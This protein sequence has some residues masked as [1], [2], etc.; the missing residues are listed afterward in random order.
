MESAHHFFKWNDLESEPGIFDST[1]IA[2]N[3]GAV[4]WV[5]PYYDLRV[6][7]TI[8]I[9]NTVEKE[10]PSDL[11]DTPY[12]DPL[13]IERFKIMLDTL[14]AHIPDVDLMV[15]NI[16]NE[17]DILFGTNEDEYAAFG[18]FLDSIV[19]YAK[20]R[21]ADLYDKELTIGAIM[22]LHGLISDDRG[23]L[24]AALNE[25]TDVISTTYYPLDFDF[26][27]QDPEV[28]FEDFDALIE[29]YSDSEQLIYFSECGYASSETCNSSEEQQAHFFSNVFE[30]WDLHMDRIKYLTIFKL[31]DWTEA[32]VIAFGE[33]YDI[34]DPIFLE[35]LRTLG[36]R[37]EFGDFKLAYDFILC[38]LAARD[39]CAVE[40]DLTTTVS[41]EQETIQ[42]YPQ[43]AINQLSVSLNANEIKEFTLF[44][45][46]GRIVR[47]SSSSSMMLNQIPTGIYIANVL[48]P[49]G[50]IYREKVII[51]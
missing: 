28:V 13:L 24:C 10:T 40:C 47:T 46:T 30:A 34:D 26:T 15:L 16:G 20:S 32:D 29:A 27:M 48:T 19:P 43:P 17:T 49:D 6:E 7:M 11:I 50:E 1:F 2:H 36:V 45:Q 9:T 21:Y 3:L 8:A 18:V 41:E 38:E 37:D 25:R 44:D 35:Y 39:W 12:D 51:Q 5:Y 33:Y 42:F 22:T 14:F 4:N 23:P 31:T